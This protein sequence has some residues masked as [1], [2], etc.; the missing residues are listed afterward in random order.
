MNKRK[1]QQQQPVEPESPRADLAPNLKKNRGGWGGR[2]VPGQKTQS[3]MSTE[4]VAVPAS[5]TTVMEDGEHSAVIALNESKCPEVDPSMDV[6]PFAIGHCLIVKYR[7]ESNRL[8]KII[9]RMHNKDGT[10]QYYIHYFDFNRRMDEW[11]DP[12]RVTSKPTIANPLE[13]AA[14][15]NTH[16]V[17]KK[18]V[19]KMDLASLQMQPEVVP[20]GSG[21]MSRTY[22]TVAELDHDEHEGLDE[23]QLVEHEKA[24]KVKNIRRVQL[25]K[26]IMECWYFSPFPREYLNFSGFAGCIYFCEYSLRFFATK[27]ELL[28]YQQANF[29][30]NDDSNIGASPR[31]PPGH[32]IYRDDNVSMFEL[33]GAIEKIYCQNLCYLAKLFLDHKT[34]FWDVDP[35]LFY[36]LCTRDAR[37]YH[38]VGYFS[39]EK[40]SESGYNLA[41]ILTFPSVQRKGYG[42]F[43]MEFSYALSQKEEKFGSPEK[44]LSDL[45]ALGYKSYWAAT[46]IRYLKQQVESLGSE[47]NLE[48]GV[49]DITF[50]TSI[51][52]EDVLATLQ[53]LHLLINTNPDPIADPSNNNWIL[54]CDLS[55][56]EELMM[57]YPA[58]QN[59]VTPANL[60]W[61]PY[62]V[63]DTKRDKWSLQYLR[64]Q[65]L[66]VQN[67][68][69]KIASGGADDAN[70]NSKEGE[71]A[72][73][74]GGVMMEVDDNEVNYKQRQ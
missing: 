36:V 47:D 22:T 64:T 31:H 20:Q 25:G 60:L 69:Q 19:S 21:A 63:V 28:R 50:A 2:R 38:P 15:S 61:T 43:L 59:T 46:I 13:A 37:G 35:F 11:I 56:L 26:H 42:R 30:S 70:S 62:A 23:Q 58:G 71:E 74:D 52:P 39:K 54:Q 8:A 6:E 55:R 1:G 34:L 45:G 41:C 53:S 3:P 68:Q 5:S 4:K 57:K 73:G 65:M 10:Y 16:S 40:Y 12:D 14:N 17:Q 32:E 27:E 9:E 49:C 33:D 29:F 72:H 18:T 48:I 7:D 44:P 51:Q 24:T 67:S 66:Q